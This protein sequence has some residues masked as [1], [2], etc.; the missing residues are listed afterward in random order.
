MQRTRVFNSVQC[1]TRR[2]HDGENLTG[3]RLAPH[4]RQHSLRL[5]ETLAQR[6]DSR[7]A[8]IER[9][10]A[11]GEGLEI[12]F[13]IGA[14]HG[15]ANRASSAAIGRRAPRV[16]EFARIRIV[17]AK[18]SILAGVAVLSE[19]VVH[20]KFRIIGL[21]KR[22]ETCRDVISETVGGVLHY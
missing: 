17:L 6:G 1:R 4:I 2:S 7:L 19:T 3:L 15:L 13:L 16:S 14:K 20:L 18:F 10:D 5:E 8:A 21:R 9:I 12:A 11:P 22:G